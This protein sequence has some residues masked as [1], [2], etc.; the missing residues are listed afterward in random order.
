MPRLTFPL[1]SLPS[2]TIPIFLSPKMKEN[3]AL[4]ALAKRVEGATPLGMYRSTDV[5]LLLLLHR[6]FSLHNF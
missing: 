4:A 3:P 1:C 2:G 5:S 6:N